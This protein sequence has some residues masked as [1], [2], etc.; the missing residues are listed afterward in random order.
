MNSLSIP[1]MMK[2]LL[3]TSN[4]EKNGLNDLAI[5][6]SSHSQK[7][8]EILFKPCQALYRPFDPM[9]QHAAYKHQMCN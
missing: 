3:N 8:S 6:T 1:I 2:K 5:A 7:S 9:S 4:Q